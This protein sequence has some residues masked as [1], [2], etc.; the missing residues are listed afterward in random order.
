M[1]EKVLSFE[2]ESLENDDDESYRYASDFWVE[3]RDAMDDFAMGYN[4][5][6]EEKIANAMEHLRIIGGDVLE[7][8]LLNKIR[9]IDKI[10]SKLDSFFNRRFYPRKVYSF[11][12]KRIPEIRTKLTEGR[13]YKSTDYETA[14]KYYEE[15]IQI[16]Q[17]I[18]D[19]WDQWE[20]PGMKEG[21]QKKGLF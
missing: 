1:R 10:R 13:R 15:G 21:E 17:D 11:I 8:T 6:N 5:N 18:I 12:A 3:L 9:Q 20:I 19:R 2:S 4:N 14:K 16:A 7:I